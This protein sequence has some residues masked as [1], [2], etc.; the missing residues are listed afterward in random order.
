MGRVRKRASSRHGTRYLA[1]ARLDGADTTVGT[2]ETFEE[3][4]DAWQRAE[5]EGRRRVGGS[6]AATRITFA[7]LVTEYFAS[8]N[9][10]ATTRKAYRSHCTHHL[11]PHFGIR[12]LRDLDSAAV[13]AWMNGQ[14]KAGVGLRMRIATRATLSS[15]LQFA[16]NNGR[17][18]FNPVAATRPPKRTALNRRRPVLRPDQWPTLRRQFNDYGPETQLLLDLAIDTGLRFGELTDLRPLHL[19]DRGSKPYLKIETVVVWPGEADSVSGDVVERKYYTKG[20][21]DRRVDLSAPVHGRL[22]AHL[23]SLTLGPQELIFN[24]DRI[25]AEHHAWRAVR[26]ATARELFE[27]TWQARLAAEPCASERYR[28]VRPDGK[29]RTGEH[30]RP[31]TFGLGCRCAHCTYANTTYGR[32]R[33][34]V[35]RQ[36]ERG[37]PTPRRR[38]PAPR[39][40]PEIREPWLSGQWWGEVVWRPALERAGLQWLHWHDL[41]HAHATWLLAAGVPVR[42]VQRRLG[43]KHLTT[44]EI[45]LGELTDAEDIASYLGI[46]HDI[47][48]A[49]LRGELW[50]EQAENERRVLQDAQRSVTSVDVTALGDL[51]AQLPPD[52]VATLLADALSRP[53]RQAAAAPASGSDR[54]G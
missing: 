4:T 41:R 2:F 37:D 52:Q 3:A 53:A 42:S 7:E 20:V 6:L 13:G 22:R 10:E 45:Y 39:G 34:A 49:A 47:F 40:R 54:A 29:V 25:R 46:Y 30:G 50:D 18:A 5:V 27:A 17:I 11:L 28:I 33:R 43:H 23:D 38:G 35:R 21:E 36:T 51:L 14:A 44:T 15:I 1:F 9:L 19:V 24:A 8:A 12:Q 31:G 48:A 26:D 16:A 32:T